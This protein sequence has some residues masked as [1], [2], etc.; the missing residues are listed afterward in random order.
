MLTEEGMKKILLLTSMILVTN[1]ANA[2]IEYYASVK[3]DVGNADIYVDSDTKI[4]DSVSQSINEH[5]GA[6]HTYDGSGFLWGLSTAVG[7]D[8]SPNS[9]YVNQSPYSWFHLRLEGEVGYNSYSEDGNIRYNYAVTDDVNVEFNHF[10]LLANG[11]A[12]FRINR[13]IPYVGFGLGYSFGK[14]ELTVTGDYFDGGFS[15]SASDNGMLYALYLGVGYKYS[16]ITTFEL[17]ARRVYA[18]AEDDGMYIYDSVR[19]GARFRI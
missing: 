9:M 3:M 12:D 19:L 11:Y 10:F 4:G 13:V 18:P 1:I 8:W 14:E 2:Q 5:V 16:D 17:G 15:D 6:G 7:L